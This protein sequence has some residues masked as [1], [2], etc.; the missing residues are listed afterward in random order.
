MK[1]N[2]TGFIA[3][4]MRYHSITNLL[5]MVFIVLGVVALLKMPRN[6]FPKFTIRQ[7]VIVGVYPGAS[8]SEVEE[9]LTKQVENYIF[10]Y[11][12]VKKAQN[13][14]RIERWHHVHLC[15]TERQRY[16]CR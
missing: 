8:S 2:K 3:W 7:G 1:K 14:F 5:V 13:V 6:E 15:R 12:E 16:Q 9:Q 4:A 11:K 10:G